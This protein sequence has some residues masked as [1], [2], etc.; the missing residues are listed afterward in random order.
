MRVQEI[1][2]E[3]LDKI[4]DLQTVPDNTTLAAV[5]P[6]GDDVNRFKQISDL[7]DDPSR[8]QQYSNQPNEQYADPDSVTVNAGGGVNG[9]KHPADL[10]GNSFR[11]YPGERN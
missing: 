10:R 11:L 4:D 1:I 2:R 6:E 8:V 5:Q 3:L 7:L 9:P